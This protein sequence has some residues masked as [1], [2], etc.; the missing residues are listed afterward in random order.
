MSVIRG[1]ALVRPVTEPPKAGADR[2]KAEHYADAGSKSAARIGAAPKAFRNRPDDGVP[3]GAAEESGDNNY[4][5]N[6]EAHR[7]APEPRDVLSVLAEFVHA[8]EVA[9]RANETAQRTERGDLHPQ[10][11]ENAPRRSRRRDEQRQKNYNGK[12]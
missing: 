5:E 6:G 12:Q 1:S 10:R 11:P 2:L 4:G 8:G 9:K 3:V 7:A